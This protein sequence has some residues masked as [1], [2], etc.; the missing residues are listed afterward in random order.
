MNHCNLLLS[1][2]FFAVIVC[3]TLIFPAL[4]RDSWAQANVQQAGEQIASEG[5]LAALVAP[6]ALYPDPLVAQVLMASTYPIEVADAY[7]WL[8]ANS[9]LQEDALNAALMQQNWDVSVKSLVSFP[10]VLDMMGSQLSWTQQLGNT[11]LTQ[12]ADLMNAIQALRNKA[13]EA[14]HLS[15]TEQQLVTTEGNSANTTIVIQPANPQVVYVPTYNTAVIYGTW[16]YPAYPPMAYYPP[17]Y[18]A[19]SAILSF[20]LGIAVGSALWGDCH[21]GNRSITINNNHFNRFSQTTVRHW[22]NNNRTDVSQWRADSQRLTQNR[23]VLSKNA[24]ANA[25]REQLRQNLNKNVLPKVE[26]D[27]AGKNLINSS[28]ANTVSDRR[29]AINR[30][31]PDGERFATHARGSGFGN[32]EK[33]RL[34]GGANF[35]ART[36]AGARAGGGARGGGGL[37]R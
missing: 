1:S 12:Q 14:G 28:R 30:T 6:I 29:D 11:V 5:E 21:W 9:S 34:S 17:G 3:A 33:A 35:G 10:A 32:V 26:R 16:S 13:K 27:S 36:G 15:S 19:G 18:V 2:R 8:R 22:S 25:E 24:Q 4:V 23:T 20:G 7:H 31:R 37:R